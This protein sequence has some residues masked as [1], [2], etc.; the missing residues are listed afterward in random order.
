MFLITSFVIYSRSRS[1]GSDVDGC[2]PLYKKRFRAVARA[3]P[4][5]QEFEWKP[6]PELTWNWKF[7]RAAEGS[8]QVEEDAQIDFDKIVNGD[9]PQ[10]GVLMLAQVSRSDIPLV[11][12]NFQSSFQSN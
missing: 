7:S 6:T 1:Q 3:H 10:S 2:R 8:L 9:V 5:L 11:Q 4:S 12:S